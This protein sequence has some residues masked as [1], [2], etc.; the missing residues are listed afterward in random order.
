MGSINEDVEFIEFLDI[1]LNFGQF[2][3]IALLPPLQSGGVNQS[4]MRD[5]L[6]IPIDLIPLPLQPIPDLPDLLLR[7]ALSE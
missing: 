2:L 5:L 4:D 1:C 7:E 6:V 3:L